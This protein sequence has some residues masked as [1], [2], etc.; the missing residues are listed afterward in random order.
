MNFTNCSL[1]MSNLILDSCIFNDAT[2]FL[3]IQ[4]PEQILLENI[5]FNNIEIQDLTVQSEQNFITITNSFSDEF[6]KIY[7]LTFSKTKSLGSK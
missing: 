2:S 6:I 1:K 4:K 5:I 7:N 3:F